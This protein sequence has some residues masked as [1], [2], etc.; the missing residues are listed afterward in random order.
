MRFSL[1]AWTWSLR[2]Y[3]PILL[4]VA[5]LVQRF[6]LVWIFT[7]FLSAEPV[8]HAVYYVFLVYEAP[9]VLAIGIVTGVLLKRHVREGAR[10]R[11]LLLTLVV[12]TVILICVFAALFPAEIGGAL[13]G[14]WADP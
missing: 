5:F 1:L 8:P 11:T 12:Q 2:L 10:W 6:L 7:S 4:T 14:T 3:G 13:K 9:L